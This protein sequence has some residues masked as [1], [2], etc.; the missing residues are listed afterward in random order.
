[1]IA[2]KCL[3]AASMTKT[4]AGARALEASEKGTRLE[5]FGEY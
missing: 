4:G 2:N 3:N 1:M 5:L